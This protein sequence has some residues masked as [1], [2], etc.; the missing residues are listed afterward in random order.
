MTAKESCWGTVTLLRFAPSAA[1]SD[2]VG[3]SYP[4]ILIPAGTIVGFRF[5][6][7]IEILDD[8]IVEQTE[9]FNVSLFDNVNDSEFH[10]DEASVRILDDADSELN[11]Y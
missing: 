8:S 3:V 10:I 5:Y 7:Y 1:N 9:Y 4:H 2:F 11:T 6:F